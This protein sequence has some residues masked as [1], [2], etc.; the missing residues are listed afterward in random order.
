MPETLAREVERVGADLVVIARRDPSSPPWLS[1]DGAL[2][3]IIARSRVPV[4]VVPD[5]WS[6]DQAPARVGVGADG[7]PQSAV[8]IAWAAAFAAS[9]GA[10][11]WVVHAADIGPALAGAGDAGAGYDRALRDRRTIVDREWA[12]PLRGAA[13][14]Y[15]T[16]VEDGPPVGLLF[17]SA[18]RY[19][20]DLLVVGA[21]GADEATAARLGSVAHRVASLAPS[22]CVVVPPES[23]RA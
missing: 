13:V 7:S 2:H 19:G 3:Q 21:R 5:A 22:P 1:L 17:E 6:A 14:P 9:V 18:S 12:R 20:L 23:G 4:A 10:A 8:A 11:A 16:V 15:E